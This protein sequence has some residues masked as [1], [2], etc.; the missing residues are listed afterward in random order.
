MEP[1][2]GKNDNQT[3]IYI[4]MCVCIHSLCITIP[5][6]P[7]KV[8]IIMMMALSKVLLLIKPTIIIIVAVV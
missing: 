7:S 2:T 6:S 3:E 1:Y 8:W 5:Y 4:Y